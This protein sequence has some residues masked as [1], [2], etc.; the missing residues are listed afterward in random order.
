MPARDRC[1]VVLLFALTVVHAQPAPEPDT[2]AP[3][4][5]KALRW[6]S[7]GPYRG[8]RV[9][10]VSGVPG[11]PNVYY[12]G[13]TGGGVWKTDDGGIPWNPITDRYVKTGSVGALAV[14]PSDPNV[15]Y[16]GM[17]EADIR[18]NFSH[19]DGVYKSVD[20]GRTWKHVGLS[21]S[22]QIGRIAVHPENPAVAFV[23]ALGHPFGPNQERGLFRT[24]DGGATW[25]K[26]L[27]V[28]D[29]T[30]AIDVI[31]DPVNPRI[32]YA[33]F[34]PVYRRPWEIYSG[35]NGS[36]PYK[37]I[38]GGSTWSELSGGLPVGMKGRIGRAVSPTRHD[39]LWA[40]VEAKDGGGSGPTMRVQHGSA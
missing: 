12:M 38:D 11:Q 6:R 3:A 17:G 34:W 31:I 32:V 30:G 14:A 10:A 39:R 27:F 40:I 16:V 24:R 19:G 8:G 13:A 21:D 35:G 18:S 1:L 25:E 4:L 29:K 28:D 26:V 5:L 9:T 7:I 37:S 20:A 33:S 15:V 22:R 2:Y 23:A 36:G